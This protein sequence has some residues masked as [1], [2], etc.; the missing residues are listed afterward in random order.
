MFTAVVSD[1]ARVTDFRSPDL[2][3]GADRGLAR[4]ALDRETFGCT[5]GSV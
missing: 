3:Q 5:D 4:L 2:P 1:P